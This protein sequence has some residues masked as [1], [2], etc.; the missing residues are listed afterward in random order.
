MRIAKKRKPFGAGKV[1]LFLLSSPEAGPAAWL[2]HASLSLQPS[3]Q[4]R[5][6]IAQK[7]NFGAGKVFLFLL[8][9]PE[10]GP[11]AW[12]AHASVSLQ[13]SRQLRVR[14]ANKG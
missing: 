5:V 13:P 6:R 11:A 12:L 14:I 1:F 9:S 3:R 7:K 8:S 10:A 2:A 4:L